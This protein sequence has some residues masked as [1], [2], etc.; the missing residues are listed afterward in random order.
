M[1]KFQY[2][3]GEGFCRF[4]VSDSD[5]AL[6]NY[7]PAVIFFIDKMDG[8]AA[9][10]RAGIY[11]GLMHKVPVHAF[12]AE[13]REK[14]GVDIHHWGN[15]QNGGGKFFHVARKTDQVRLD[16]I[17]F[18]DGIRGFVS[19]YEEGNI[20]FICFLNGAYAGL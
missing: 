9:Y 8:G 14:R 6:Q 10:A 2:F 11:D 4:S 20:I 17:E 18:F 7:R 16:F 3:R 15:Q 12:A 1:F 5:C 19:F 13:G